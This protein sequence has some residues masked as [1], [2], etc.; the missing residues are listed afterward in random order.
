MT[1]TTVLHRSIVQVRP[2]KWF[3]LKNKWQSRFLLAAFRL[4]KRELS[5]SGSVTARAAAEWW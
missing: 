3:A 5:V 2:E 1:L 4:A